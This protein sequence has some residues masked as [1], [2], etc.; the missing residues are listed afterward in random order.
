[1][2]PN[3]FSLARMSVNRAYTGTFSSVITENNLLNNFKTIN[4][5]VIFIYIHKRAKCLESYPL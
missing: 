5:E 2:S 3:I 1:M 4:L